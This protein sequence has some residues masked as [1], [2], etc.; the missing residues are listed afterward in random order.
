MARSLLSSRFAACLFG[1]AALLPCIMV[2]AQVRV[3]PNR[4]TI[5][6]GNRTFQTLTR[7]N[8]RSPW[9]VTDAQGVDFQLAGYDGTK[10]GGSSSGG[11]GT[12]GGTPVI[13]VG[14]YDAAGGGGSSSGGGG[15][16]GGT[17]VII[18]GGYDAV[19]NI[20]TSE[21]GAVV[22]RDPTT[23]ADFITFPSQADPIGYFFQVIT[24]VKYQGYFLYQYLRLIEASTAGSFGTPTYTYATTNRRPAAIPNDP[25]YTLQWNMDATGMGLAQWHPAPARKRARVAIIDSGVGTGQR[26]HPGLDGTRIRYVEVAPTT[27]APVPHGLFTTTLFADANQDGN[28]IS[29]LIGNWGDNECYDTPSLYEEGA[30]E[31]F[32]YNVGDYGPVSPFVARAIR[33]ATRAGV[34]VINMSLHLAPSAIV[35][36]AIV[37]AQQAGVIVVASAGNYSASASARPVTFPASVAGV[38]AVGAANDKRRPASFS[39]TDGVD[40]YAPGTEIVA[41]GPNRTWIYQDGTSFAAPHVAATIALMRTGDP[42]ITAGQALSI[43]R[44]SAKWVGGTPFLDALEA[45]STALPAR[46][47]ARFP[48]VNRGCERDDNLAQEHDLLLTMGEAVQTGLTNVFPNPARGAASV[49]LGLSEAQRVRVSLYDMLGRE[50][51]VLADGTV[52]A[53]HHRY[54]IEARDLPAGAYV[55]RMVTASGSFSRPLTLLD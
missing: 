35:E 16:A 15:T 6:R 8:A 31:V 55:V 42:S 52:G 39:A 25:L 20:L 23:G 53:G 1:V 18:V 17:P 51:A 43:L 12:A 3:Q 2:Q 5:E 38:I 45:V 11:G 24:T 44:S 48:Q 30:P 14:G 21:H 27:G 7:S 54:A 10:G 26:N 13:I 4:I 29:S 36:E 34:D 32:V 46:G 33:L 49:T 40:L 22:E 50:V 28:G 41:G 37:A 19:I 9:T 47:K